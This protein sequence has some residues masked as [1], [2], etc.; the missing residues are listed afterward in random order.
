MTPQRIRNIRRRGHHTEAFT[1]V[2]VLLSLSIL[3]MLM[4]AVGGAVFASLDSYEEND[5]IAAA[6]QA[7]RS[8]LDRITRD[9][10]TAAAVSAGSTQIT[11]ITPDGSE[12]QQIDYEWDTGNGVLYYRRTVD[13][14]TT[15]YPLLGDGEVAIDSF[16]VTYQTG[17]YWKDP[18]ILCTKSVSV[19]I[20]IA[21]DGKTFTM[22]ASAAPRRNQL[23]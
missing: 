22:T 13:G 12:A 5:H 8:V 1:L 16:Y 3:A 18:N 17:P 14:S 9:I 20:S 2:E 11:I 10:R 23:Y 19:S 4:A 7:A 6:T 21:I 15:S